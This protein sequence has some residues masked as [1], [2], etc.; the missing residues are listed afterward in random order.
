MRAAPWRLGK[1]EM[2]G[3][4]P[5]SE[6]FDPRTSTSVVGLWI[7]RYSRRPTEREPR[8]LLCLSHSPQP[9]MRQPGFLTPALPPARQRGRQTW[10]HSMEANCSPLWLRQPRA[11]RRNSCGWH[12]FFALI[13]RGR[14]LSARRS[15]SASSVEAVHPQANLLYN[16]S[17]IFST[18]EA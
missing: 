7:S 17:G 10:P 8:Q 4:E 9:A 13:L 15:G 2:A 6:R 11:E 12:L 16:T 14:R 18:V 1:V 3:I 5:A